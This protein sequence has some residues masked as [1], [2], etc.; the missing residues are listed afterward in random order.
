MAPR[1]VTNFERFIHQRYEHA[2][3]LLASDP[4]GAETIF[5]ELLEEPK[6]P[7]WTR[8]Q[9][10][11]CLAFLADDVHTASRYLADGRHVLDLYKQSRSEQLESMQADLTA[12]EDSLDEAGRDIAYRKAHPEEEDGSDEEVGEEDSSDEEAGEE[13][14]LTSEVAQKPAEAE[15]EEE[16][17]MLLGHIGD[18]YED[19]LTAGVNEMLLGQSGDSKATVPARTPAPDADR[20]DADSEYTPR[21]VFST[22]SQVSQDTSGTVFSQSSQ[23]V[24]EDTDAE[25][26]VRGDNSGDR[27]E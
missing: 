12:I 4:D 7:L 20:M 10:N 15:D 11:A 16:D 22:Q 3:A 8:T 9:C 5:V 27:R 6:L 13:Q 26:T 19:Q 1:L 2:H 23:T 17:E 14:G 24:C 25:S 21:T 18:P